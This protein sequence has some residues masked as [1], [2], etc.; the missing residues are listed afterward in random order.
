MKVVKMTRR[1]AGEDLKSQYE[2]CIEFLGIFFSHLVEE[3]ND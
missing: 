3:M 2:E 1:L